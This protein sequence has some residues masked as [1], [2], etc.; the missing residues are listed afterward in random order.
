M[1][2]SPQRRCCQTLT[3]P[4]DEST[5]TAP[6]VQI[7]VTEPRIE[8]EVM[9]DEDSEPPDTSVQTSVPSPVYSPP[10]DLR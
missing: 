3:K 5:D 6:P 8:E 1:A 10:S 4:L 2:A 9:E 7:E